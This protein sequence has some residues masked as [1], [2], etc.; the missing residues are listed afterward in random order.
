MRVLPFRA[1]CAHQNPVCGLHLCAA[2][3]ERLAALSADI[4]LEVNV[5]VGLDKIV[6]AAVDLL[7]AQRVLVF[8]VI[9]GC[10]LEVLACSD[11]STQSRHSRL[12]SLRIPIDE[13]LVKSGSGDQVS[14]AVG[15]NF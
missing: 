15:V 2:Q 9:N 3:L 14:C 12:S 7:A 11:A 13:A 10:E 6:A 4:T 1:K 5:H 8:S